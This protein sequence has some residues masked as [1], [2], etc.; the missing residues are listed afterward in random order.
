MFLAY[1]IIILILQIISITVTKDIIE[2]QKLKL[3]EDLERWILI[4]YRKAN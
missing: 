4:L 3:N 1:H 2:I